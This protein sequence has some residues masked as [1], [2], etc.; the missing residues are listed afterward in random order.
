MP[1][2][3]YHTGWRGVVRGPIFLDDEDRALFLRELARTQRTHRWKVELYCLLTNHLHL[4]IE[5]PLA[6]LSAGM[7]RLGSGYAR[8]FNARHRRRGHVFEQRFWSSLIKSEAE[9]EV[10]AAY[11]RQNP[12]SAGVCKDPAD[13]PW[14]GGRLERP[15]SSQRTWAYV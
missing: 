4:L 13:W 15:R 14:L 6:N 7:Q 2:G 8:R 5:T 11:I 10:V 1:G 3:I 9:L 12:V